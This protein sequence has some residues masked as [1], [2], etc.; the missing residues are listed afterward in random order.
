MAA[1]MST[2]IRIA[3][4]KVVPE[5]G[6]L[7]VNHE[8]LISVFSEIKAHTP[9]VV[10][11]PECFLDGYVCTE[12]RIDST[13]ISEYAVNPSNSSFVK[14]IS[15][16]SRENSAWVILG[17][18]RLSS[19]GVYNTAL[20]LDR[21]GRLKGKYDKIHC[22]TH[23]KKY[24]AGQKL[25]AFYSDFGPFGVMICA[26]RRWPETVRSLALQGARIIFNPTYGI[27]NDKNMHMM[28]TRSYESELFIA[29][30]HPM[31][32][33]LTDP[34]GQIIC[35]ETRKQVTFTMCEIDLLEADKVR[36][37][38]SAHLKDRRPELYI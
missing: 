28:Q 26:D 5:K 4:I 11:T 17:C 16:W 33:L 18:S 20:V 35:N 15:R 32:S 27:H 34:T 10:V 21:K 37:G 36:A 23:D 3:Q 29:F 1:H 30:T 7:R 8:K 38:D 9:D 14:S 13:N 31:Q 24:L 25:A 2:R 12:E 19:E 22:Q 6:N